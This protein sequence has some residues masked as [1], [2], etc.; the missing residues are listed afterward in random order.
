MNSTLGCTVPLISSYRGCQRLYNQIILC[1][2]GDIILV[3]CWSNVFTKKVFPHDV[4]PETLA[5]KGCLKTKVIGGGGGYASLRGGGGGYV[6]LHGG[7][8]GGGGGGNPGGG[9][10]GGG[11]GNLGGGGGGGGWAILEEEEEEEDTF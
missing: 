9:G 2:V 8:D 4:G 10:G 3:H 11:G 1:G 7:G 5:V 6:S